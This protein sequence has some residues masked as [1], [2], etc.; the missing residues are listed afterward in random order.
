MTSVYDTDLTDEQ[1]DLVANL[2]APAKIARPRIYGARQLLNAI[3]YVLR[4]GCQ[5]RLIPH[6]FPHW[7]SVYYHF[8]RWEHEGA[9]D[10]MLETLLPLTRKKG[11]STKSL[12][13][14]LSTLDRSNRLKA[15][16]PWESMETRKYTEERLK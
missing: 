4:S 2:F 7:Q 10:K 8:K 3:F 13:Q 6:D 1:W 5:W 12:I 16:K 9:F 15:G 11:G 14:C